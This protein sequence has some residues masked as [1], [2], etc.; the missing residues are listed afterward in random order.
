MDKREQQEKL[1][2]SLSAANAL[3]G[4]DAWQTGWNKEPES[5]GRP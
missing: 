2:Q 1:S 5:S 4:N 3:F